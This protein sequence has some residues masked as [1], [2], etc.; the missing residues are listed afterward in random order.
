VCDSLARARS[1]DGSAFTTLVRLHQ[2]AVYSLALRML[3]DPHQAEDLAQEVFI[4]LYRKLALVQSE[5]HLVFWLRQVTTRLAIDRL[6]RRE[7]RHEPL[8]EEDSGIASAP[9]EPDPLLQ[10]QLRALIARLPAAA[11]AV[12]VLRYQEDLDPVD[13]ARVLEMPV[14]TV[15]SHLKR[16]LAS[17]REMLTGQTT[18]STSGDG[19]TP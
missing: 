13:I 8:P 14:N 7:P 4:R 18:A 6:R 11:R 17:L 16:S 1:G 10:R 2:R 15:K 12:V 19:G 9:V 5:A 3:A